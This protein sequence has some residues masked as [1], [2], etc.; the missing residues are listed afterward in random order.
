MLRDSLLFICKLSLGKKK[1]QI[2]F[3][4]DGMNHLTELFHCFVV[5]SYIF[6]LNPRFLLIHI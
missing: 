1:Y 5:V 4:K 6:K 2:L 3:Q